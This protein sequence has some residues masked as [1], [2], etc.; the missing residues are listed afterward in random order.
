[1]TV[2]S[3]DGLEE[4]DTD[5]SAVLLLELEEEDLFWVESLEND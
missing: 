2:L 1:M 5:S 4:L 3:L